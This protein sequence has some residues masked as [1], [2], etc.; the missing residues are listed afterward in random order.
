MSSQIENAVNNLVDL[1]AN[2]HTGALL[3]AL[4]YDN[5][6]DDIHS[7]QVLMNTFNWQ[8]PIWVSVSSCNY[9]YNPTTK[10]QDPVSGSLVLGAEVIGA[11]FQEAHLLFAAR[12]AYFLATWE[13]FHPR[14]LASKSTFGDYKIPFPD[15][16][17]EPYTDEE[18]LEIETMN[19]LLAYVKMWRTKVATTTTAWLFLRQAIRYR[20]HP[21]PIHLPAP[22]S[23][24]PIYVVLH[25]FGRPY[26]VEQTEGFPHFGYCDAKE[27]YEKV[28]EALMQ[29]LAHSPGP[30]NH[31]FLKTCSQTEEFTYSG[32]YDKY[33]PQMDEEGVEPPKTPLKAANRIP[34]P[35]WEVQNTEKNDW[36]TTST[37]SQETV[38]VNWDDLME[39]C[40]RNN[41]VATNQV[42][43]EF[44]TE[45]GKFGF[46]K[47][48]FGFINFCGPEPLGQIIW[49]QW[50][51]APCSSPKDEHI[52]YLSN[53]ASTSELPKTN[54]ELINQTIDSIQEQLKNCILGDKMEA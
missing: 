10:K 36:G 43:D 33:W 15:E 52:P 23:N 21:L 35:D 19:D 47:L 48:P 40:E 6:V 26:R 44:F 51:P 1:M 49:P 17:P 20:G 25:Y 54:M 14:D 30:L 42:A 45:K 53:G 27:D 12:A 2:P 29:V 39:Y 37:S 46:T 34:L 32:Y 7:F 22:Y 4:F 41:L 28:R 8:Y 24:E 38:E 3:D 18:Y 31:R 13:K 11:D 9:E 50:P 16:V 5:T